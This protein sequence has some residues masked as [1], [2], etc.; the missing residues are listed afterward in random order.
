M[1]TACVYLTYGPTRTAHD[2]LPGWAYQ[3][4]TFPGWFFRYKECKVPSDR[5]PTRIHFFPVQSLNECEAAKQHLFAAL[6]DVF[7]WTNAEAF[8]V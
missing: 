4:A 3:R 1:M 5:P 2:H 6:Y 7:K 8:R